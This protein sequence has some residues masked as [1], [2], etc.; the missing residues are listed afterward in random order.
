MQSNLAPGPL[1]LQDGTPVRL[2]FNHN[3]S[4]A[5][6]TVGQSVD[7]EVLEEVVV[8]GVTLIP[9]SGTAM[10]TVT[11]AE[12]KRT[13]GRA[14]KL[15]I[16]LDF[17]RLVDNEKAPIRAVKQ[18]KGGSHTAGMTI[19]IV[20]TSLVFLPAAPL[21][22]FIHG[23]DITIPKG[24]EVI[25]YINGDMKL[26]AANFSHAA[27]PTPKIVPGT[28]TAGNSVGTNN[29]LS[30]TQGSASTP[31]TTVTVNST[32]PGADIL[33]DDDFAGDTPSTL[34]IS[35]G[36]HVVRVRKTGFQEWVRNVNLNGGSVTLNA[37]LAPSTDEV[38]TA[39]V[40]ADS[41]KESVTTVDSTIPSQK[42]VGWIG[43][44]AQNKGDVALVTSVIS[45]SPGAKAGIQPGDVIL[46][47]DGRL[48]KGKDFE[49][50]VAALKPGTQIS[51]NYARGSS[52]HEVS[53][54]V[55]SHQ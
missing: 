28:S 37:E 22:L 38:R 45:D 33:V 7:L 41:N 51:V 9:K 24:A 50:A 44:Q 19:G 1:I 52:A 54:T 20:A 6:A 11:E 15:E 53:I 30:A 43:V 12:P 47:L 35:A 13:M 8:N 21:L 32:P 46:A 49:S 34:N 29:S 14:G 25:G 10:A 3:V 2:R 4:S 5:D 55:S 26:N 31:Q 17:V 39:T 48:M 42:S 36:K 18:A 16:V 40:M 27:E 23:K